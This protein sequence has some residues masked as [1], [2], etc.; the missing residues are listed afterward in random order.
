MKFKKLLIG[1]TAVAGAAL[2]MAGCSSKSNST[3][4]SSDSG[5]KKVTI[6][7][8]WW[9]DD[10]RNA[11]TKKMVKA[12][13]KKNPN[14]TVKPEIIPI[15]SLDQKIGT[16]MSG[17]TEPDVM[18]GLYAWLPQ[19]SSKGD[20]Y[21]NLSKYKDQIDLTQYSSKVLAQG[22][23]NGV[24][25]GIAHGANTMELCLNWTAFKKYGITEVPKTWDDYVAAAKKMPS[26]VHPIV[27]PDPT[28]MVITYLQQLTGKAPYTASNK[29]NY[30]E[31]QIK[32]GLKWY[33][34][35]VDKN[36]FVSR[37]DYLNAVGSHALP[38]ASTS[39]WIN[40][41][42]AGDYEWSGG[43][44]AN[45]TALKDKNA[46]IKIAPIPTI[47]GAKTTGAITKP[48]FIFVISKHTK[49]PKEAAKFLNYFLNSKEGNKILGATRGVPNSKVAA[50]TL[51]DNGDVK[52]VTK[53]AYDYG[54]KVEAIAEV[55]NFE[56]SDVMKAWQDQLES[57]QL[58]KSN[59]N[60]TAKA[61]YSGLKS[62]LSKLQ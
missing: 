57:L 25:N 50:Q 22:K 45:E 48:T 41:Q 34:D 10:A 61:V 62:A 7:F 6:R 28:F 29:L 59:V 46:E 20:G 13:E 60:T 21:L 19:F 40:G 37:K 14:I 56:N 35:M 2:L 15:A 43:L 11:A 27:V 49:H 55:P 32:Q 5:S 52:G 54:K 58:G 17:G 23:S 36:V 44:S 26:G 42:W 1:A 33:N 39:K 53:D 3:T 4:N 31:S 51:I 8:S 12:F 30:S 18:Q 9:G 38:V 47:K 24:L 16:Q